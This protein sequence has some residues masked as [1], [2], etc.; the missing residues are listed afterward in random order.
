MD[1]VP[2]WRAGVYTIWDGDVF[3]YVGMGG[4]G[5]TTEVQTAL[6]TL[7]A[8]KRKGPSI[9]CTAT[10]RSQERRPVLHYVFDRL[11]L[12]SLARIDIDE[13]AEGRMSLDTKVRA[14]VHD[15]LTYRYF[16]VRDN[17]HA[18]ELERL[19]RRQ[20]LSGIR[21]RFNPHIALHGRAGAVWT[22]QDQSLLAIASSGTGF[23][24]VVGRVAGTDTR[25]R[26]PSDPRDEIARSRRAARPCGAVAAVLTVTGARRPALHQVRGDAT[27]PGRRSSLPGPP[28]SLGDWYH[29]E[30]AFGAISADRIA[31]EGHP[32]NQKGIEGR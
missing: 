2:S 13:A 5:L 11:V 9:G 7:R 18:A 32:P 31:E 17:Q 1:Q 29:S 10:P 30:P 8:T 22:I 27:P 24:A 26:G 15:R 28:L 25:G 14:Y 21:P 4:R 6:P 19:V 16:L 23:D 3:L 20:G 12:P